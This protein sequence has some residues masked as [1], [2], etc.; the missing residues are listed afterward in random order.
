MKLQSVILF[1]VSI[2]FFSSCEKEYS[3]EN[4]DTPTG[5]GTSGG[6]AVYTF[7][8]GS[9]SCTSAVIAGVYKVAT[10]MI[11]SNTATIRVTVTT[12]GT[13]TLSTA[14][15]NGI[16]FSGS[17]TFSSA[18]IQTIVLTG[19]GTPTAAG[20][21][22]FKP[23]TNGC[24]FSVTVLE[25]GSTPAEFSFDGG[26]ATCTGALINGVYK[27]GIAAT[28]ANMV[29]L[30]VNVTKTG[31]YNIGTAT[32]NGIT[33]NG[34]GSFTT[35]GSQNLVL[36]AAGTPAAAGDFNY[37]AGTNG[38]QF[39]VSVLPPAAAAA[40]TLAGAPGAC[41]GML[42]GG[43]YKMGSALNTTNLVTVKVDVTTVGAFTISTNTVNGM[44]FA[45]SAEFTQTG[46]QDVVLFGAG[47]PAA[48]G[49]FT[50]IPT[51]GNQGCS[52]EVIVT[53]NSGG[54]ITDYYFDVTIAGERIEKHADFSP[55]G[56]VLGYGTAGFDDVVYSSIISPTTEPAPLNMPSISVSKGLF[57][58]SLSATNE[59]F[60]NYFLPG[61]YTYAAAGSD[62][63][64]G[65]YYVDKTL[66]E[67]STNFGSGLQTG[68][69]FAITSS[70]GGFDL[71]GGYIVKFTA[72]FSCKLYDE[73]GNS[74]NLTNGK[75]VGEF[76]K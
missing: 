76:Q 4:G 13:Y 42:I 49:T 5:G 37:T 36:T 45:V 10:T 19:S 28:T 54:G 73:A 71:L 32:I 33:F 14:T 72:T 1:L 17:G 56:Y 65:I 40:F 12:A 20:A 15:I 35:T 11:A 60:K 39:S 50:F 70:E 3:V 21:F 8:D 51:G 53:D 63:G 6:T 38:C 25:A 34:T 57:I 46:Q 24:N 2:F 18:G 26:T 67:W 44:T 55:S 48:A 41:T 69:T 22:S 31:F 23:G 47:T 75:F 52:F 43:T 68:S 7:T 61:N 58:G 74:I 16:S 62:E 30:K 66:K 27:A 9:A 59:A 64:V 29:T